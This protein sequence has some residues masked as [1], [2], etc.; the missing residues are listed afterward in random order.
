M[1]SIFSNF[2]VRKCNFGALVVVFF[3]VG[4]IPIFWLIWSLDICKVVTKL[5]QS[6]KLLDNSGQCNKLQ[7]DYE[8]VNRVVNEIVRSI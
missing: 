4:D 6:N 3:C 1:L 2:P 8:F 7:K 5:L